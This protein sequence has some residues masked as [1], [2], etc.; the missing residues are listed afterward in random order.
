MRRT[1]SILALVVT[2]YLATGLAQL[3]HLLEAH[4]DGQ[5]VQA[6]CTHCC[7]GAPAGTPTDTPRAPDRRPDRAPDRDQGGGCGT[8][9]LLASLRSDGIW[10]LAPPAFF[11]ALALDDRVEAVGI[12]GSI[13]AI[14]EARPRGP[15]AAMTRLV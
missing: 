15:P 1:A 7:S 6:T 3:A 4:G 2:A 14:G 9:V 10:L 13:A 11:T 12:A 8:C 5:T